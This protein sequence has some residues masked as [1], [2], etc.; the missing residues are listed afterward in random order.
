M[1]KFK[2]KV[3]IVYKLGFEGDIEYTTKEFE[4]KEEAE[5][6]CERKN[7]ANNRWGDGIYYYVE[8]EV[9]DKAQMQKMRE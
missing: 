2:I 7:S 1:K 5:R 4:S 3:I 6:W 9:N 8:G